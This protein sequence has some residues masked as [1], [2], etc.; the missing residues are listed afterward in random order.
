MKKNDKQIMGDSIDS[1]IEENER[2]R[3][4]IAIL[5]AE[6]EEQLNNDIEEKFDESLDD[7][8]RNDN[9]RTSLDMF[10][11]P[12][13]GGP[14]YPY[15]GYP[16][17]IGDWPPGPQIGDTPRNPLPDDYRPYPF[18]WWGIYPPEWNWPPN[19]N[20]VNTN[21]TG[22]YKPQKCHTVSSTEEK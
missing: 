1:L 13:S 19:P 6:K 12:K 8:L 10:Y 17:Q 11:W 21:T 5:E 15:P 20:T 4:R 18:A 14:Y 16:P 9:Q 2:L 22:D 7:I 3:K